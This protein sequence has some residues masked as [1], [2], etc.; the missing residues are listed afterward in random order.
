VG[1]EKKKL[2]NR[3]GGRLNGNVPG[4]RVFRGGRGDAFLVGESRKS[5][6]NAKA[7]RER[8]ENPKRGGD[9]RLKL[10]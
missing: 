1:K 3:G 9:Q 2:K 7:G 4:T 8:K 5:K 10:L 6:S